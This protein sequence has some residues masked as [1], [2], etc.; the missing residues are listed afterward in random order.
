MKKTFQINTRGIS[1]D[2]IRADGSGKFVGRGRMSREELL[3]LLQKTADMKPPKRESRGSS[4]PP[5]IRVKGPSGV[6]N[7][8][9]GEGRL[10]VQEA[11]AYAGPF[12]AAM[13]ASG[14]TS[15]AEF[16]AA[17]PPVDRRP[18]SAPPEAPE[19]PARYVRL[20]L[21]SALSLVILLAGVSI[22]VALFSSNKDM[23]VRSFGVVVILVTFYFNRKIF[24][25]V[26]GPGGRR[27]KKTRRP[28]E[29][30]MAPYALES[31]SYSSGEDDSG[32]GAGGDGGGSGGDSGGDD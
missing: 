24:R 14:N 31:D 13:L 32:N 12:E 3:T 27:P 10:Y 15:L 28:A 21:A 1:K 17:H 16:T 18:A 7:F 8:I 6:F 29:D 5:Q 25:A 11:A 9:G 20:A 26:R 30:P 19:G 4:N 23:L 2:L 22:G